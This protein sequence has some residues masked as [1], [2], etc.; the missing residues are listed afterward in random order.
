M[1]KLIIEPGKSIGDI[2]I[3]MSKAE[4]ERILENNS[5]FYKVEFDSKDLTTFVEIGSG[6]FFETLLVGG[7]LDNIDPFK[8]KAEELIMNLDKVSPYK[9]NNYWFPHLGISFWRPTVFKEEQMQED[10]FK[11]MSPEDQ[12]YEMRYM[13][14]EAIAVFKPEL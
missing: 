6:D 3:G 12:E 11:E 13:F 9:R 8:T 14:F 2:A 10:W 4:V 5:I 7:L 1:S